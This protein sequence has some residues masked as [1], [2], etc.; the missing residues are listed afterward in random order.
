M[1]T[2]PGGIHADRQVFEYSLRELTAERG[3][4]GRFWPA[5]APF[6]RVLIGGGFWH[7]GLRDKLSL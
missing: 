3:P 2:I 7:H 4:A 6:N 1:D 5:A